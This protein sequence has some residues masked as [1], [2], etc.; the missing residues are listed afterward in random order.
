[1]C[2]MHLS[3]QVQADKRTTPSNL[4]R[5]QTEESVNAGFLEM[6]ED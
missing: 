2:D 1:M 5:V 3:S 4:T 6:E